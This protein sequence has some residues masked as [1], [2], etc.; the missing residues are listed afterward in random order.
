MAGKKNET[1]EQKLL[2][3][4]EASAGPGAVSSNKVQENAKRKQNILTVIRGVNLFLFVAIILGVCFIIYQIKTG[5]D[6]ANKAIVFTEPSVIPSKTAAT[7]SSKS[8][9]SKDLEIYMANIR[10]RNFFYPYEKPK[11]SGPGENLQST[12]VSNLTK[13]LRLVGVSWLDSAES[14]S[15]MLEDTD[16]NQT[17]FLMKN[18][19]IGDIFVKTIYAD[20]VLLG[21]KNEEIVIRYD[22]PKQ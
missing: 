8:D 2:K 5:S 14:A 7:I 6:M 10:K 19:K 21:Y 12:D 17:Y 4:I 9:A 18:E 1:A 3:M 20:S 13:K 15:V 16:K 11:A 22:T